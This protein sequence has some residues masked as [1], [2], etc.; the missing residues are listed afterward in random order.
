M[1]GLRQIA[2]QDLRDIMSDVTGFLWPCTITN[3]EG[4]SVD[5][6]CRS[7]DIWFKLDPGT[8]EIVT[9]RQATV[10]VLTSE[11]ADAGFSDICGIAESTSKPWLV[12][13][14]DIDGTSAKYKVSETYPDRTLGLMVCIL[15]GWTE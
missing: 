13:V 6:D 11:L 9:A 7:N 8:G 12:T 3:P 15:E 4:D 10:T 5:F 1:A 14:E 2:K